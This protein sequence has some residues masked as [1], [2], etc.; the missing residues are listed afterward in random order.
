[1]YDLLVIGGGPG[2]ATCARR[3][4]LEG[5]NVALIEREKY[6]Q[7]KIC[8][9]ALS[10]RTSDLLDFDISELVERSFNSVIVHRP[11]GKITVLTREGFRGRLIQREQFDELLLMKAKEAGVDVIEGTEIIS[12]EQLRKG[13]R[14]LS[15]GNSFKG[16]LLV[17][18]DGVNGKSMEQLGIRSQWAQED[19]GLCIQ[20]D[21]PLERDQIQQLTKQD[22]NTERCA[23]ELYYGFVEWGYGWCFPLKNKLNIGIGCRLDKA[24]TLRKKWAT[25]CTMISKEKGIDLGNLQHNSARV[26]MGGTKQ[27]YIARRSMLVGDSAGLVSP[28]TGEGISYAIESGILAADIAVKAVNSKAPTHIIEYERNL[29]RGIVKELH[30]LRFIAGILNKSKKN[31]ELVCDIADDDIIMRDYL[32]DIL[33]RT[34]TFSDV[35]SKI[36][37]RLLS[38]HPLKAI[39]L[40]L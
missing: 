7:R 26:P 21:V 14:A 37:K 25:F 4:A 29:K 39:R 22:E 23:I 33:T 35:K 16:H 19:V 5:L 18:A 15:I 3:A 1:M 38:H 30:D 24:T 34:R 31:L 36:V 28:A 8:G 9:G 40:G 20:A 27:R 32:V 2:G 17:G 11:S 12:I 6:P 13:I 10:P